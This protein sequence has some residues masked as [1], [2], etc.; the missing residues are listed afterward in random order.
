MTTRPATGIDDDSELLLPKQT[1]DMPGVRVVAGP[2]LFHR[3][4]HGKKTRTVREKDADSQK[5]LG[6]VSF[7]VWDSRSLDFLGG[8]GWLRRLWWLARRSPEGYSGEMRR[9]TAEFIEMT[10]RNG[11]SWRNG[12]AEGGA[13]FKK[14]ETKTDR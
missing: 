2:K 3:K 1:L 10:A 14:S 12:S 5:K 6:T 8:M 4:R 9:Q 7:W 13:V 11:A